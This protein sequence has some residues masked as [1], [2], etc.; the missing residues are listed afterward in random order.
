M[1]VIDGLMMFGDGLEMPLK[2][3][4]LQS[5]IMGRGLVWEDW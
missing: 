1:L 2:L 4:K 3:R 5:K